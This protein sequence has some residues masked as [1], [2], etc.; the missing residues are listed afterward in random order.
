MA[1]L[2]NGGEKQKPIFNWLKEYL[3]G[4]KNYRFSKPSLNPLLLHNA[5]Y[6][7]VVVQFVKMP[8]AQPPNSQL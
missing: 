1:K 4:L 5:E 8:D 3:F 2:T 7:I 6:Q